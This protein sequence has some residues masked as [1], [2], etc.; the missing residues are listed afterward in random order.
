M[1]LLSR[2]Q[3]LEENAKIKREKNSPIF[4][5]FQIL[6]HFA[7]AAGHAVVFYGFGLL[8]SVAGFLTVPIHILN[9][10]YRPGLTGLTG[11]LK[12]R[13]LTDLYTLFCST[14]AYISQRFEQ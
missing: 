8:Q 9:M 7:C 5:N 14:L 3:Y 4:L 12:S 2:L 10:V 11:W 6:R 1:P 13:Q